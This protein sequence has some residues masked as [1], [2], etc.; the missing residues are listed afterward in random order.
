MENGQK[1]QEGSL[2][3]MGEDGS[4]RKIA[5][6][7]EAIIQTENLLKEAQEKTGR[8]VRSI[9]RIQGSFETIL[10]NVKIPY[11]A[12]LSLLYGFKVTN[13]WLKMHGGIM[14]RNGGKRKR[15]SEGK[16]R[17]RRKSGRKKIHIYS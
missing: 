12:R 13:N 11:R 5:T 16:N 10:E 1:I 7:S 17:R 8:E 14:E 6:I 15:R 4:Q 2:Y 3:I 9:M